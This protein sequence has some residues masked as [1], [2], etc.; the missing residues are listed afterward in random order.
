M[1]NNET[2]SSLSQPEHFTRHSM[3]VEQACSK[4]RRGLGAVSVEK[5]MQDAQEALSLADPGVP[6]ESIKW[7]RSVLQGD[8]LAAS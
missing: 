2:H 3:A 1:C 4:T 6:T 7:L 5:A 8:L